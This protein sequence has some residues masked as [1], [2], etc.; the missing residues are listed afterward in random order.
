MKES[1]PY[2]SQRNRAAGMFE[3]GTL[4]SA[5]VSGKKVDMEAAKEQIRRRR[6]GEDK[7]E[8]QDKEKARREKTLWKYRESWKSA[9]LG[10]KIGKIHP[11]SAGWLN[12]RVEFPDGTV[13]FIKSEN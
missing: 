8:L 6:S 10:N 3:A 11:D 4:G 1:V 5:K 7:R 9:T 12:Q 13:E 2:R